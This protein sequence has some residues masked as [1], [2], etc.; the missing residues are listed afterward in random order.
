M[1]TPP[2][3][4]MTDA[5]RKDRDRLNKIR[6]SLWKASKPCLRPGCNCT[7]VKSHW[8]QRKGLLSNITA[9]DGYIVQYSPGSAFSEGGFER[10][11]AKKSA[12]TWFPGFCDDCDT[13]VFSPIENGS[14]VFTDF[15]HQLLFSYRTVLNKLRKMELLTESNNKALF[16][17]SGISLG[18]KKH[19]NN[20][21]R[22][23]LYKVKYLHYYKHLLDR[24]IYFDAKDSAFST[25][26]ISLPKVEI[27]ATV[28]INGGPIPAITYSELLK[29]SPLIFARPEFTMNH[30]FVTI[31]PTENSLELVMCWL[32]ESAGSINY[33]LLSSTQLAATSHEDVFKEISDMLIGP[34]DHW[35]MSD[36]FYNQ[37]QAKGMDERAIWLKRQ[38]IDRVDRGLE[39]DFQGF[40]LFEGAF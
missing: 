17:D 40:S 20:N 27:A 38:N 30:I 25:A 3:R 26:H 37:L 23:L 36:T 7:A 16:W 13:K 11:S 19:I 29:V 1:Y 10:K 24:E 4:K 28:I 5:D 35:V 6:D 9:E 18:W 15:K 34:G 22:E 39:L 2:R 8:L 31:I 21:K 33:P 32:T 14:P 12:M